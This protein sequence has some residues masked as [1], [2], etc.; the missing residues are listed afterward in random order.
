VRAKAVSLDVANAN[1][2]AWWERRTPCKG[3]V[4]DALP[5]ESRTTWV[6]LL[7]PKVVNEATSCVVHLAGTGDH[8]YGRRMRMAEPLLAQ[9]LPPPA[10]LPDMKSKMKIVGVGCSDL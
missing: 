1:G 9:V 10:T 7:T 8:G 5:K 2:N 6:Q 4:W 3:R